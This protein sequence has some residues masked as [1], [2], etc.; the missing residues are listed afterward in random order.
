MIYYL[1]LGIFI[2]VYLCEVVFG[3]CTG[4]YNAEIGYV[5]NCEQIKKI[6]QKQ[7]FTELLP[8]L[9]FAVGLPLL[10]CNIISSF[11]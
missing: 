8:I 3:S 10:I 1:L 9:I 11:K 4:V 5:S 2:A 6:T 7:Y